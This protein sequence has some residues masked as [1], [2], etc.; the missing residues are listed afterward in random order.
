MSFPTSI[1]VVDV[2][3]GFPSSQ[4]GRIVDRH[5][6][7]LKDS[8]SQ[9]M[10]THPAEYMFRDVP[11]PI[12]ADRDP[13]EV[14]LSE[15]DR[16]GIEVG[17]VGMVAGAENDVQRR[18]LRDH[19]GRFRGHLH[20]DPNDFGQSVRLIREAAEQRQICA[21]S[22]FPAAVQ[23]G[24]ADRRFYPIY[25][26]CVDLDLPI[27]LNAGIAGPRF[28]SYEV[29]HVGQFDQVCYE[30][31]ELRIVMCHGAEPWEDLAVKLML[32]YPG[33]HY[34]PS[35]FLPRYYPRAIIDFA[36]TRGGDKIIY[37]GYYP[38]GLTLDRI[39]ADLQNLPLRDQVWPKFLRDN[40]FRVFRLDGQ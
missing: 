30:F 26:T 33:L 13:V 11:E 27:I 3:I 6:A 7:R 38:M 31:P 29:Q 14:T 12:D 22:A 10:S 1:G 28:P 8:A 9:A 36:N 39:F 2:Y 17:I 35:A 4:K 19:P 20:V 37:G 25:Q 32:K 16:F 21:V 5:R 40:A 18:A 24:I 15:M 23:V 34:T